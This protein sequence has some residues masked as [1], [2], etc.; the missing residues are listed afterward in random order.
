V[1]LLFRNILEANPTIES[2]N[3][4]A[5]KNYNATSC[6]GSFENKDVFFYF[7]NLSSL[8]QQLAL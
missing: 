8:P 5:V 2:Y 1:R 7:E 4:G 3:A 6:L